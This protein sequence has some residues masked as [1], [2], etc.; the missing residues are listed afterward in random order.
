MLLVEGRLGDLVRAGIEVHVE[1]AADGR[2]ERREKPVVVGLRDRVELVVV[3]AGAA[4]GEA[5][6]GGAGGRG[7]V[8][9]RV[10]ARPLDFVGRDLRRKDAG[11]EKA[12][13]LQGQRVLRRELVAGE[14]PPHELVVTACPG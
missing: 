7:H 11:A 13:R 10:V 5:E 4:D 12:G 6:H 3:A 2:R 14:L 1:V 9:E 8:V